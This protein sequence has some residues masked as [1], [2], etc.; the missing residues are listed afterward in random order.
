MRARMRARLVILLA[1]LTVLTA[2]PE[3][4]TAQRRQSVQTTTI[5]RQRQ[6]QASQTATVQKISSV[7][8]TRIV[9][10]RSDYRSYRSGYYGY[11]YGGYYTLDGYAAPLAIGGAAAA[12]A[13]KSSPAGVIGGVVLGWL[14]GQYLDERKVQQPVETVEWY[15]D[16]S[17]GRYW[18]KAGTQTRRV[19]PAWVGQ[20]VQSLPSS[21]PEEL[22][23]TP[24]P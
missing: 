21:G 7:R 12:T 4:A 24:V 16:S 18:R 9:R 22:P 20:S 6:P 1:G 11:G 15:E 10:S 17:G 13:L 8:T 3:Q 23:A 5:R 19:R 2:L 14:L